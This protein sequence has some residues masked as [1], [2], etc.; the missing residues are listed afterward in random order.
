MFK[1]PQ[2]QVLCKR[3]GEPRRFIQ[4]LRGPRQ[5][6]KTTLARQVMDEA[7]VPSHYATGD[8]PGLKGRDWLVQQWETARARASGTT[9]ALLV[10]DE[11]QKIPDW[12]ETIKR[13]WDED[14]FNQLP[15]HVFLLGS[16]ALLVQRG[17][18]ESLAGRYETTT[19]SHW[20]FPEMRDAFG[21]DWKKFI[22]FGGYPGAAP[23][24]DDYERWS[25][26][27]LESLIEPTVSRDILM[28]TQVGK[29]ALLR[30]LFD[31]GCVYSGQILSYQKM[32]GQLQDAG[33]TTT[34]AHYL[35]LLEQA[36]L[37]AGLRKFSGGKVRRRV[38]SPKLLTLNTALMTTAHRISYEEALRQKGFWGRLVESAVGA[39][40]YNGLV[41]VGADIHYWAGRNREVDYVIS[42]NR[43][44]VAIEVK[45]GSRRAS[46]PGMTEFSKQ[47]QVKKKLLI[48]GDGIPLEE[49]L[50][51]RMQTWLD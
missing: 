31:L 14:T 12:S 30:Q 9:A 41:E 29:P 6:G 45:S 51:S 26:Y 10:L 37:L 21:F 19:I 49:F 32:L 11:V 2:Y 40:L 35:Q 22:F 46:L 13:L 8:E 48:G 36:G 33:N 34:L 1:R 4:V 39:V 17:L 50:A 28:M 43:E 16:S 24:V 23:L 38:S 20:S 42:R 3:I 44:V 47:F 7:G 5:T 25:R 15:L 27:V 18:S